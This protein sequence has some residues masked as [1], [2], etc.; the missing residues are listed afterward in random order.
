VIS[1]P[2]GLLDRYSLPSPRYTSY[3]TVMHWGAPPTESAWLTSLDTVLGAATARC[4]V[5]VHVPFCQSLCT[6]CGCNMRL[7]RNHALA[8]PY[9]DTLLQEFS[10]YR[11]RLALPQLALGELHLGGGSP[12]WLPAAA[13][14]RMLDGILQHCQIAP[15]ADLAIEVDPR[16]TTREQLHVLRRHGFNRLSIGVQDFDARVLEIV[17]RTQSE[18]EVR[19]LVEDARELGFASLSFDLIFGLPLQTTDSLRTTLD[20]T[21]QLRPD[22]IAFLPYAHVPWI[23][24]SQRRYTDADLPEPTLRQQ[25]FALGRE[26]LGAAGFVEIGMDQYARRNDALAQA[27][28]AGCLHRNFMGFSA[29]P[30]Q[31]LIGLGVS[32]IGD[33]RSGYAQNEKN[34]QQYEARV[35]AQTLPLQRGHALT[36]TDLAIRQLLWNLLTCSRTA[37]ASTDK[38]SAWWPQTHTALQQLHQDGLVTLQDDAIVVTEAGRAL[39]RHVGTAFDQYLRPAH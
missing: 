35:Q 24:Q 34:L 36:A 9:V 29:T 15:G 20:I 3:P 37:I 10:L 18:A 26:R 4:A 1:L 33:S 38:A 19:R 27:L 32:A 30:T 7:A 13:L 23:K 14:D 25:L 31:A 11:Q 21:E 17:N 22:R 8:A 28:V 12:T 16:N 39:L 2:P 5:Y 6:F